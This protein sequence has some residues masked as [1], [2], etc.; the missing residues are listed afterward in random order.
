VSD[1]NLDFSVDPSATDPAA[2][3][4]DALPRVDQLEHHLG[5]EESASPGPAGAL[6]RS[7]TEDIA[8]FA[9]FP[10]VYRIRAKDFMERDGDVREE[11]RQ[12]SRGS[13][14]YRIEFPVNLFPRASWSFDRLEVRIEFN[15]GEPGNARPKAFQV[16]PNRQLADLASWTYDVRVHVKSDLSL[17]AEVPPVPPVRSVAAE[18]GAG[19][20]A[21]LT[22][23]PFDYKLRRMVIETSAPGLEKVFWRLDDAKFLREDSPRLIVITQ[24][25]NAATSVVAACVLQA[26]RNYDFLSDRVRNTF[27]ELPRAVRNYFQNGAPVPAEAIYDLTTECVP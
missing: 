18:A 19:V 2:I 24:V 6:L 9:A 23:G 8:E 27:R 14:F 26:Y 22:L 7:M 15:P 20:G 25:P 21:T 16:F 12:L 5:A 4:A 13:R 10:T 17:S 11:F 1:Q 3:L